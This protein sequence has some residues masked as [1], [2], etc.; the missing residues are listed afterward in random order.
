MPY[1]YAILTHSLHLYIDASREIVLVFAILLCGAVC[2]NDIIVL[3]S[4]NMDLVVRTAYMPKPG[5][6]V[7]GSTF[8]T[9]PGGKGAN[10]AA[11]AAKLGARVAMIGQ[12]GADTFG[13][14]LLA[15]M[16]H[17]HVGTT[18]VL[19]DPDAP[20][21]IALIIVDDAGENSIVVAPG[22]NGRITTARLAQS[23]AAL[24]SAQLLVAQLEV[25]LDAVQAAMRWANARHIPIVL[26]A[27]PAR[28]VPEGFL[29]GIDYLIVNE[30]EATCLSGHTVTDVSS[31]TIAA[32]RLAAAGAQAVIVT[33]GAAGALLF[34]DGKATHVPARH[35]QAVDTTAAGDAFVGGLSVSLLRGR[36]L[37]D[38]VR[39]ATCTGTL[40]AMTFGAQTS[41][42]TADQV[43]QFFQAAS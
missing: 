2:M 3:G 32:E 26:N 33:L 35:V 21:G 20:T 19:R 15:T 39:Y 8:Q 13:H 23:L 37:L 36:P 43:D 27:A 17:Q 28:Q 25:P 1:W 11:A 34:V 29:R 14:E 31:A 40:A 4:L 5:E 6:T 18:E 10:Q 41:L 22:A 12:V 16:E 42:P 38:A 24:G 7:G 30:S 9:I